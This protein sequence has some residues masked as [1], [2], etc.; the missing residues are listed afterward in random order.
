MKLLGVRLINGKKLDKLL[1]NKHYF[2]ACREDYYDNFFTKKEKRFL[3]EVY[4][5]V[6]KR[7]NG[8]YY[9][10]FTNSLPSPMGHSYKKRELPG[11]MTG[12]NTEIVS[13]ETCY[14]IR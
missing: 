14:L 4:L 1:N 3:K 10:Q 8:Q 6:Y 13:C 9:V 5:T 11:K 2:G 7:P 12:Y